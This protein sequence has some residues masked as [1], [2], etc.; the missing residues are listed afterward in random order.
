MTSQTVVRVCCLFL[1][2]FLRNLRDEVMDSVL[3][4][5]RS[6]L[7]PSPTFLKIGVHNPGDRINAALWIQS[8]EF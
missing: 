7:P 6:T 2:L 8:F 5:G 4:K 1:Y 3:Q